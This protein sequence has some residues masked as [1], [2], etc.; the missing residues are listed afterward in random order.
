[1]QN[2]KIAQSAL[3]MHRSPSSDFGQNPKLPPLPNE[4]APPQQSPSRV[5]NAPAGEQ[6]GAG[7]QVPPLHCPVPLQ[8]EPFALMT[9]TPDWH[10]L[11]EWF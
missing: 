6:F 2:E 10:S 11:H 4:Q 5:H 1:L 8:P 9:Q 3:V 7:V